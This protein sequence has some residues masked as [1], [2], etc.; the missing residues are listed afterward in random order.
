MSTTNIELV[1]AETFS[2]KIGKKTRLPTLTTPIQQ[3]LEVLARKI[4]Q[5]IK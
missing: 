3:V 5:K 1:K 4:R 2:S